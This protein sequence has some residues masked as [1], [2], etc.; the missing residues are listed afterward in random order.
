MTVP[1]VVKLAVT[2]S[3]LATVPAA[4]AVCV[5]VAARTGKR[6][7][8]AVVFAA[9]VVPV[10]VEVAV[11]GQVGRDR[12]ESGQAAR[13]GRGHR[14][15][16]VDSWLNDSQRDKFERWQLTARTYFDPAG[17]RRLFAEASYRGDYYWT[18]TE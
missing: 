12:V 13:V 1:L 14:Y 7:P 15:V 4:D 3:E 6:M 10:P 17:W 2:T 18:V 16:Q 5:T 8:E 11:A 9:L